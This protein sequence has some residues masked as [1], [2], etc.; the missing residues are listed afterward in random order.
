M[1]VVHHGGDLIGYHS[2][3]FWIPDAQVGG[4][5]LTNADLGAAMLRGPLVRRL[6]EVLYDGEREA[7]EDVMTAIAR[8]KEAIV[9]ERKRL[10][11]PAEA[12]IAGKLAAQYHEKSLGELIVSKRGEDTWF[13]FGEWKSSVASRKNDDGTF[14]FY[15]IDPG[16]AGGEFVVGEKDGKRTLDH[17]RR[18][19]RVR[20]RRAVTRLLLLQRLCLRAPRALLRRAARATGGARAS[21]APPPA[22]TVALRDSP[23]PSRD[24][25]CAG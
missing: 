11:T 13:D 3:M 10:V 23:L 6:L 5:I 12:V 24:R 2:D 21:R 7:E 4:V 18:A 25:R 9:V 17:A 14:S 16:S 1:P 22:A 19:A 8:H 15:T 20:L